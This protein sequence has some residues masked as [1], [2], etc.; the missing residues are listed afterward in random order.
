MWL[1][2]CFVFSKV[3]LMFISPKSLCLASTCTVDGQCINSVWPLGGTTITHSWIPK[4]CLVVIYEL[5]FQQYDAIKSCVC[6]CVGRCWTRWWWTE[7]PPPTCPTWTCTWTDDSSRQCR[8]TVRA[9][10]SVAAREAVSGRH[11]GAAV[12]VV[13]VL[14]LTPHPSHPPPPSLQGWSCPRPLAALRTPPPR[15]PPWSTPT[16][17]PSWSLPSALTR[18]PSG[19]S[20]CRLGW[21]SW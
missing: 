20:W 19:P 7:A 4:C 16:C 12:T 9:E 17:R 11:H 3:L 15:E 18:C 5:W 2:H 14:P 21:S 6:V 8:A 13:P 1:I 10:L